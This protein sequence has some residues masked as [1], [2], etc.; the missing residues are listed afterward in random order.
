MKIYYDKDA[1]LADLKKRKVAVIGYGSQG[2]AQAQ[3]LKDSKINV[4]VSELKGSKVWKQVPKRRKRC[5]IG[6]KHGL[7]ESRLKRRLR[8]CKK[9]TRNKWNVLQNPAHPSGWLIC[10]PSK[11]KNRSPLLGCKIS[12]K[13]IE[14]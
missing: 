13:N 9:L 4:V 10:K 14:F 7:K 6:F 8:L 12:K 1:K 11:I 2:H 3:N 5:R